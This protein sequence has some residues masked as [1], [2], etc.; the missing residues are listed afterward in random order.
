MVVHATGQCIIAGRSVGVTGSSRYE[1]VLQA[2]KSAKGTAIR[3]VACGAYEK[4]SGRNRRALALCLLRQLH[5]ANPMIIHAV[6]KHT[7]A[8][9]IIGVTGSA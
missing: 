5:V 9:C 4:V 2:A 3:V 7:I 8:R 1:P 6:R